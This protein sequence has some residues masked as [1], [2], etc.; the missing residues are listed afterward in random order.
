LHWCAR[1]SV[2]AA[3]CLGTTAQAGSDD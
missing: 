3:W 1:T 2:Y